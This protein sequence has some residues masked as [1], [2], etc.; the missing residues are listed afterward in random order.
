MAH[1]PYG[2]KIIDGKAVVDK[3]E[4]ENIREFYKGY[5]SGLALKVAAENAGLKLSHSSA[6]MMLRKRYYLG[7]DFY[8]AII[9]KETFDKAEEMRIVRASSLGRIREIEKR[10]EPKPMVHFIM[11]KVQLKYAD[12]FE[13]AKYAYGLIESGVTE[14]E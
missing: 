4:A 7:D 5:I 1:I 2:Y 12:P 14:D 8:P 3:E 13:Q 11:P 9:D 6:G 10:E